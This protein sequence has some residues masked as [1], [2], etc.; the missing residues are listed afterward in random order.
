[1]DIVVTFLAILELVKRRL[2]QAK[3]DNLFGEIEVE[4]VDGW[5][6]GDDFELEFGE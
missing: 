2:V 5:D 6:E 3:Q 4:P 1:M